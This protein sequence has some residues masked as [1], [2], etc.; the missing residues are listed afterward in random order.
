VQSTL[1]EVSE[2]GSNERLRDVGSSTESIVGSLS[3][4]NDG[5]SRWDIGTP[6]GSLKSRR[7]VTGESSLE[8]LRDV[9]LGSET[10]GN[11]S[12][13]DLD[14]SA[15]SVESV[16]IAVWGAGSIES[17]KGPR[18]SSESLRD[19]DCHE[20]WGDAA[21][22]RSVD[23]VHSTDYFTPCSEDLR[24]LGST[25]DTTV[26][27]LYAKQVAPSSSVKSEFVDLPRV[28]KALADRGVLA[29]TSGENCLD[30]AHCSCVI[31]SNSFYC[32]ELSTPEP[33]PSH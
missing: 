17:I 18:W 28:P 32:V 5:E 31:L 33:H 22:C 16:H 12:V 2:L 7:D 29:P 26:Q 23:A 1:P 4:R 9:T 13:R 10:T 8:S 27:K 15:E 3:V 11:G 14:W 21:S 19:T 6:Q 30:G 24:A 20:V 25:P